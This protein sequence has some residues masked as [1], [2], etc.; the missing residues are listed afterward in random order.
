MFLN[1]YLRRLS[2]FNPKVTGVTFQTPIPLLFRNF[3]IRVLKFFK[4]ENPTPLQTPAPIDPTEIHPCFYSRNDHAKSCYCWNWNRIAFYFLGNSGFLASKL[5]FCAHYSKIGLSDGANLG[6]NCQKPLCF[7]QLSL[8]IFCL[9][10]ECPNFREKIQLNINHC[11]LTFW[12]P[13]T[14]L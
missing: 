14:F 13:S 11:E 1:L 3:R 8:V 12:S 9:W 7:C 5:A 10:N 6:E 4:F 2:S